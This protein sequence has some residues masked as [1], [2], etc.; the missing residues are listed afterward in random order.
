MA[1][2]HINTFNVTYL[3]IKLLAASTFSKIL[4]STQHQQSP[5]H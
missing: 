5:I 2:L 1:L 4:Y 3:T